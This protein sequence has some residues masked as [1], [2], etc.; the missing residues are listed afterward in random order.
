[1]VTDAQTLLTYSQSTNPNSPHYADQTKLFSAS[2]WTTDHF[3]KAD[4]L[5]A[6]LSTL[7]LRG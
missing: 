7:R 3:C 6:T 5:K 2:K 1:M 4:V